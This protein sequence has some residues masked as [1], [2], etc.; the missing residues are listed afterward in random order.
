MGGVNS[1]PNYIREMGLGEF[2]S[3]H[4]TDPV[5]QG[6]IVSIVR[7]NNPLATTLRSRA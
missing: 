1:S 3:G 6:G 2:P 4:V 7:F 5:H